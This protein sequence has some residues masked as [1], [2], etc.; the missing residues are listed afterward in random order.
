MRRKLGALILA[1]FLVFV[2][3]ANLT[4]D[5]EKLE[6]WENSDYWKD[7]PRKAYP[8]WFLVLYG[9]TPTITLS[10]EVSEEDGIF[11]YRFT[12]NHRY[13]DKPNDVRFH[14]FSRR[15][16]VKISVIR[17]DGTELTLYNGRPVSENMTLNVNMKYQ[18]EREISTI[19]GIS[20][21]SYILVPPTHLLFIAG[22]SFETLRG[23]YVFEVRSSEPL[24]LRME[25]IGTCYGLMGTD[26]KGRD[27]WVG[28]VK[29]MNNTLFLAFFTAV[30]VVVFGAII[31]MVSGYVGGV[32]GETMSFILEVLVALPL[33]PMLVVLVWLFSTQ[34]YGEQV[35][36]NPVIFMSLVAVMTMGKLAKTVKMMTMK[37]KVNE[38]VKAAEIMGAGPLW[39]LR[40]HIF[41]PVLSFSARYFATLLVRVVA[42]ISLFGF[43]GLIPGTNWGSFMIEAMREGAIYGGCWWWILPPGLTMAV[44]SAGLVLVLPS[45]EVLSLSLG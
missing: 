43:F 25:V 3:V 19:F 9:K 12:Y 11:V 40:K 27:L 30:L 7:Y 44:L 5:R 41:P 37:E 35:Q 6:N 29:A 16:K 38:Y 32:L 34:G 21:E 33:L 26:S 18:V 24:S 13:S 10:P 28:F 1:G 2:A 39:V 31:G 14:G 42:L 17:P 8:S 23:E 15:T 22:P 36:I 20:L 4:V 45:G